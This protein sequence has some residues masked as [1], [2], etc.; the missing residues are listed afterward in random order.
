MK[1]RV[2]MDE[3]N[4]IDWLGGIIGGFEPGTVALVGAGCGDGSLISVRGAVRL[5][6]AD[7]VLYDETID[8]VL[9]DLMRPDAQRIDVE[10]RQGEARWTPGTIQQTLVQHAKAGRRVVRLMEGDPFVSGRAGEACAYLADAF[11][12]LSFECGIQYQRF[13]Y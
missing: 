2:N 7:V 3:V 4:R 5:M 12:V 1:K 6:Q 11:R 13:L 8:S 9:L 10:K